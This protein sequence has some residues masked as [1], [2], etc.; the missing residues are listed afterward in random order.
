MPVKKL[1]GKVGVSRAYIY[2]IE[3]GEKGLKN[4]KCLKNITSVLEIPD[5]EVEAAVKED[6][7]QEGLNRW[8]SNA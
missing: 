1:A 4:M 6:W 7:A 8:R 5:I 3:S 2:A